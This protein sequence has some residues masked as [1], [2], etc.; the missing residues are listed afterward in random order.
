MAR[1]DT[2]LNAP[3][4]DAFI[5]RSKSWPAAGVRLAFAC[6]IA[7]LLLSTNAAAQGVPAAC[8][9][10]LDTADIVAHDFQVSFCELC[11]IGTVRLVIENPYR[12][13]D[14]ADFSDIVISDDLMI[15][16]LTYLPGTTRFNAT[17]IAPPP[18]V[19]PVISGANGSVLTWN[20]SDQF[21]MPAQ[22]LGGGGNRA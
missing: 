7:G 3:A 14:D 2:S 8:P 13:R 6:I 10:G 22:A 4:I 19:E 17:N 1:A 20:V 5:G 11:D 12:P 9:A 18:L 21:V 15:S 16:G